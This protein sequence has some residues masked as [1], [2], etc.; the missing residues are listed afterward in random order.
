MKKSVPHSMNNTVKNHSELAFW[1]LYFC[2]T[3]KMFCLPN[4]GTIL[5]CSPRIVPDPFIYF[6]NFHQFLQIRFYVTTSGKPTFITKGR[7]NC[8]PLYISMDLYTNPVPSTHQIKQLTI[9][10]QI[11]SAFSH[12]FAIVIAAPSYLP[13]STH[14]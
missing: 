6:V 8:F 9:I 13:P 12:Y 14:L 5:F 11:Y 2:S 7:K 1:N 3:V 10:P 4:G